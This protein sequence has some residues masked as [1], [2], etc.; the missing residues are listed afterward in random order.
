M[1]GD[2]VK[3]SKKQIFWNTPFY[4]N[5]KR[6]NYRIYSIYYGR[7]IFLH[8]FYYCYWFMVRSNLNIKLEI[9]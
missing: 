4:Y 8:I 7:A 3:L 6:N 9:P 2:N 5:F 1:G